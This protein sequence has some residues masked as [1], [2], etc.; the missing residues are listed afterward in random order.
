MFTEKKRVS[1]GLKILDERLDGL[2]I[3]DNVIWYDEAGSLAFPF[4]LNFIRE[5]QH[6]NKP[7]IYVC[8]D[9][10][11]KTLIEE[12]GPLA[13]NAHLTN[14]FIMRRKK[15]HGTSTSRKASGYFFKYSSKLN[16]ISVLGL[17][18]RRYTCRGYLQ[19]F[20]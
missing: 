20:S 7:L 5:S 6:R 19:I 16:K 13:E 1:T 2:L 4:T 3:G 9:R 15:F 11:P 8:F 10:S 12:L 18:P 14:L 17:P